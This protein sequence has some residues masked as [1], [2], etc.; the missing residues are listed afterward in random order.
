MNKSEKLREKIKENFDFKAT[1]QQNE[2]ISDVSDFVCTLGNNS[3][4]LLKGYAGTGKTS[5]I[6]SF[7]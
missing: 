7:S 1:P 5:L 2:V 6:S 4:F 3:I